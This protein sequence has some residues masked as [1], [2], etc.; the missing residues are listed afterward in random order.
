MY[1]TLLNKEG[2][3]MFNL[4]KILSVEFDVTNENLFLGYIDLFIRNVFWIPYLYSFD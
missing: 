1:K 4:S 3:L 2:M